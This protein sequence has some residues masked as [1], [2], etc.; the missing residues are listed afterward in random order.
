M[1]IAIP[2]SS[3]NVTAGVDDRFGRCPFFCIYN[4]DTMEVFFLEN[5]LREESGGIGPQVAE[6]LANEGVKRVYSIEIGPKAQDVLNKFHIR[7]EL[8]STGHSIQQLIDH[9]NSDKI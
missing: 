7:T 5:K 1:K 2:S 4:D 9:F 6:M 8:V 3:D